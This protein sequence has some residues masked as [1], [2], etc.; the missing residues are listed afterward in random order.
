MELEKLDSYVQ[1]I[2]NGLFTLCTKINSEYI[3]KLKGIN[4]WK[5]FLGE[6]IGR[7]LFGI[8]YSNIFYGSIA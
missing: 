5:K 6:N 3:K 4:I 2:Q 8:N 7:T 1:R